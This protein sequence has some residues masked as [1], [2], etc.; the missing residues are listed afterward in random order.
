[1]ADYER[2]P[3]IEG[4]AHYYGDVVRQVLIVTAALMLIAAPFY[5]DN[6]RVELPFEVAGALIL[7][8]IAALIS[9]HNRSAMFGSAIATGVGVVLFETWALYSYG[10][11]SVAQFT[12][13]QIIALSFLTGF[14]FSVKTVRAFVMQTIGRVGTSREFERDDEDRTK[15]MSEKG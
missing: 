7:A 10:D 1:M 9:P 11:S 14:Y 15:H 2:H 3:F 6:L 8:G 12:L 5:A 4:V 13:R